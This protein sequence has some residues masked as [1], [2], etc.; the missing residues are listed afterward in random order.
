MRYFALTDVGKRRKENQDSWL[1]YSNTRDNEF[2]IVVCDGMGGEN[3]G[4]TAS[5]LA[6]GSF[7]EHIRDCLSKTDRAAP[8][9]IIRDAASYANIR[10]Y[11]HAF[12]RPECRGMGTTLVAA[13]LLG[14]MAA[15]INI[16][17]S[18]AYLIEQ[19]GGIS[20]VTND[21]SFV[22]EL[23]ARGKITM[24]QAKNHPRRNE[25]TR[26]LGVE[27]EVKGDVF[28]LNPSPG[29]R[30]LF[31]TDGLSNQLSDEEISAFVRN[32]DT[33]EA[34]C[35]QLV[36]EV[37]ERGAPDNVTAAVLFIE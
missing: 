20:R 18:R 30:L 8:D 15:I 37:L 31:C 13:L 24:E 22:A 23:V 17:D 33:P 6:V 4:R 9:G 2:A 10:L 14:S 32:A 5:V 28:L 25:I 34:A 11:D 16:G 1:S 21:H 12:Q 7:I 3:A 19:D 35:R 36:G 26:A 27:P 29:D